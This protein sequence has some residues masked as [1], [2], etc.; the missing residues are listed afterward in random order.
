MLSRILAEFERTP[1]PLCIDEIAK[2]LEA[3]PAAVE[4]GLD[5]LVQMGRLVEIGG[6]EACSSC[7][8]RSG[9]YLIPATRR[10]F[11]PTE[12]RSQTQTAPDLPGAE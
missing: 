4:A 10:T 11:L 1:E 7:P 9:C 5:L 12:I 8:V 2:S 3:E 6:L